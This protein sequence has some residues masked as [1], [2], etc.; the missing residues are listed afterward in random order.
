MAG[1]TSRQHVFETQLPPVLVSRA[2]RPGA[3]ARSSRRTFKLRPSLGA[4]GAREGRVP[5]MAGRARRR[6]GRDSSSRQR[7]PAARLR[8][9][10]PQESAF[11]ARRAPRPR[12]W[13]RG[14]GRRPVVCAALLPSQRGRP[15]PPRR[16][17]PRRPAS[18]PPFLAYRPF[19]R[20]RPRSPSPPARSPANPIWPMSP[21]PPRDRP[22]PRPLPLPAG[23]ARLPSPSR[24]SPQSLQPTRRSSRRARVNYTVLAEGNVDSEGEEYTDDNARR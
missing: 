22:P 11:P 16:A 12:T 21:P 2:P 19:P 3:W 23:P 4:G 14:R 17:R 9:R 24:A 18:A 13:P 7:A 1:S 20:S 15:G 5:A 10:R 6:A 8:G